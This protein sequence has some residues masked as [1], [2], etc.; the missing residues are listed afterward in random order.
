M[1]FI[2]CENEFEGARIVL[3]GVAFD[4]TSTY[5][6]G[7]ATGPSAIRKESFGIETYS[8]Y[9][10]RDLCDIKVFD[11][12]DIEVETKKLIPKVA[13]E[14]LSMLEKTE[15]MT[16]Q[17]LW[18]GKFPM[19]LGGEHLVTL[20]AFRAIAKR[21]P[22]VCIV[23][24][25]AHTDLRDEWEGNPNNHS[26]VIRR[27]FD[28]IV[29]HDKKKNNKGK[30]RIFQFGIRS[31]EKAEFEFAKNNTVLTKNNFKDIDNV[32]KRIG[33][34]PVY[35]TIDLDVLDPSEMGGTGTPEAGGVRFMDLL[36]AV[37]KVFKLNVVGC[38]MVELS[39][40]FDTNGASTALACKLL[41]E[42]LLL[43]K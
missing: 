18:P 32:L 20:G 13:E 5:R 41:R 31:G 10:D 30:N 25:D 43:I 6:K 15:A 11:A 27:C 16:E 8:P 37:R 38:D 33:K 39:P 2:G 19:M 24:F 42:L 22:N 1:K 28:T 14:A 3:F 4:S 40:P 7:S 34:R 35:L 21:H 36:S 12:G 9:Q 26:T 23:H 17:I 29:E